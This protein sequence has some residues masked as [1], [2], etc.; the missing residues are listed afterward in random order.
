MGVHFYENN[1]Q[2]QQAKKE[3]V[4]DKK[5]NNRAGFVLK[6]KH[7]KL[8]R[9]SAANPLTLRGAYYLGL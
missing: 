4:Q 2:K 3:T 8:V 5:L 7:D 1:K 9:R 6:I